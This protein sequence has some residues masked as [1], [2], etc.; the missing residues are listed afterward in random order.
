MVLGN[1]FK[2]NKNP[3]LTVVNIIASIP[4]LDLQIVRFKDKTQQTPKFRYWLVFKVE[5]EAYCVLSTVTSQL[6]YIARHYRNDDIGANSVVVINKNEFN[7]PFYK[8][9]SYI[10]CNIKS[11]NIKT[12]KA[13]VDKVIDWEDGGLQKVNEKVP[14]SLQQRIINAIIN[15]NFTPQHIKEAFIR[16]RENEIIT[17]N[18]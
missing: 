8:D 13:L 4:L 11:I 10:D 2:K 9:A 1:L 7:P 18:D 17:H 12:F 5:D 3:M 6:D 14:K 16:R 15:S